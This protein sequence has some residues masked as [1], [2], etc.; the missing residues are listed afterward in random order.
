MT[1][2]PTEK[3][4][5]GHLRYGFKTLERSSNTS[6]VAMSPCYEFNKKENCEEFCILLSQGLELIYAKYTKYR[7]NCGDKVYSISTTYQS[8]LKKFVIPD[9][10]V[11]CRTSDDHPDYYTFNNWEQ[12]DNARVEMQQ[13]ADNLFKKIKLKD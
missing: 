9:D 7:P 1:F 13:F 4:G 12:C 10:D 8:Y 2:Y 3:N 6:D 5:N 11:L